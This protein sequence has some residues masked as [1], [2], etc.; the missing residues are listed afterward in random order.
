[1][2]LPARGGSN[3]FD[4]IVDPDEGRGP[5]RTT[6]N[7]TID[8]HGDPSRLDPE[9]TEQRRDIQGDRRRLTRHTVD[10]H[11][12]TRSTNSTAEVALKGARVT[13]WRKCPEDHAQRRSG[14]SSKNGSRF[15]EAGRRPTR[16]S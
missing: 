14:H 3:D 6:H 15:V 7:L 2:A 16:V 9:F 11:A 5:L 12:V 1:M 10:L 13:P 4:V 8:R